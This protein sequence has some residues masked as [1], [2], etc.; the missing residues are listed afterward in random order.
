MRQWHAQAGWQHRVTRW[1]LHRFNHVVFSTAFQQ[2]IYREHF[3]DMPSHSVLENAVPDATVEPI[4][5]T[6]H[7][8]LR[9][10]FLGRF[11]HF[12]NLD[13]LIAAM[14]DLPSC[15]LTLVGDGPAKP[16]LQRLVA[17]YD[18]HGSVAFVEPVN[19]NGRTRIFAGHDVLVIPS[20]T[21][22]SPNTALEA[23]RMGLPVLL[24][25]ET[26]LSFSLS[27][28]MILH[29]LRTPEQIVAAV[30]SVQKMHYATLA[31]GAL[32]PV[33]ARSWSDVAAE[34]KEL[35][36]SLLQA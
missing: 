32:A 15:M 11:V 8:P 2:D 24:T 29:A 5:H 27:Q 28:G 12:K 34:H 16:K 6:A 9:L 26:G 13:S 4:K 33:D 36:H 10:I 20:L 35:F 1:L 17:D 25:E 19:E 7:N 31:E 22:I 30:H 23:S 3:T 18:L 14:K 21:E